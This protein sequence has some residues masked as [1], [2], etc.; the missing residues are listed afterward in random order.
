[1]DRVDPKAEEASE[2]FFCRTETYVGLH[3]RNKTRKIKNG[4][5]RKVMRLE[6]VEV[7]E[8][9]EK[10]RGR[11]AKTTLKMGRENYI[12]SGFRRGFHLAARNPARYLFRYPPGAVQ[13]VNFR[14][15]YVG[16]FPGS[17]GDRR[18]VR[19]GSL[20]GAAGLLTPSGS[21]LG[22]RGRGIHP[23]KLC[24]EPVGG[25]AVVAAAGRV[26]K[27]CFGRH[28]GQKMPKST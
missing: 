7:E 19:T 13:P 26:G 22:S 28:T 11:K 18:Q 5:A 14:L 25:P 12:L 6:F 20:A 17:A 21:G 10:I 27:I 24:F 4:I 23:V 2:S 9:A 3:E 8:L 15:L 16:T 1:M